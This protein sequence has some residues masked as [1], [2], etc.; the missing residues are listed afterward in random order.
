LNDVDELFM[1]KLSE[2][3]RILLRKGYARL[4]GWGITRRR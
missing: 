3:H 2:G 4:G 1:E